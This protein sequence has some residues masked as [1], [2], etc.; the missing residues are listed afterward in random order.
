MT[1]NPVGA[2]AVLSRTTMGRVATAGAAEERVKMAG[3][4]L[5]THKCHKIN[6][7]RRSYDTQRAF[8][9]GFSMVLQGIG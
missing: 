2:E 5:E 3:K 7:L 1:R 8:F 9:N 4:D 6:D